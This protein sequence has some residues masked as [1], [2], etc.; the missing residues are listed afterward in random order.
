MDDWVV[1]GASG[2]ARPRAGSSNN[3][4][5]RGGVRRAAGIMQLPPVWATCPPVLRACRSRRGTRRSADDSP[6]CP[7]PRGGR[8]ACSSQ[9]GAA[10]L[11]GWL[12]QGGG[13]SGNC[14]GVACER[15]GSG[16]RL[17]EQ[18]GQ[19][20]SR[21]S[22]TCRAC[23]TNMP[24]VWHRP[25]MH[26]PGSQ[27]PSTR[28]T[29]WRVQARPAPVQGAQRCRGGGGPAGASGTVQVGSGR[30][31]AAGDDARMHAA[32]SQPSPL[33]LEPPHYTLPCTQV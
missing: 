1:V 2:K 23:G 17:Q 29:R 31:W 22:Q 5:L 33:W 7:P 32:C 26:R 20:R 6:A 10:G 25:C 14:R 28:R 21:L 11:G 4:A 13:G 8:R 3:K 9:L 12:Q 19:G 24:R 15:A 18:V 30:A 16:A 27:H